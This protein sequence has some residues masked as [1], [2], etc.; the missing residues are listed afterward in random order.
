MHHDLGEFLNREHPDKTFGVEP[1]HVLVA[2]YGS[3][4]EISFYTSLANIDVCGT[5]ITKGDSLVIL[6]D[7]TNERRCLAVRSTDRV[8]SGVSGE[9]Y[10]LLDGNV[11]DGKNLEKE[12]VLADRSRLF[13][14]VLRHFPDDAVR[15]LQKEFWELED[16]GIKL[17]KDGVEEVTSIELV[18]YFG[19][20][21]RE[22]GK[23]LHAC[24]VEWFGEVYYAI[25]DVGVDSNK[26][27]KAI[28]SNSGSVTGFGSGFRCVSSDGRE[29]ASFGGVLFVSGEKW[30][31][32]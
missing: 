13:A 31:S 20:L 26:I 21:V 5:L 15:K 32:A 24:A 2:S 7:L 1:R 27:I 23:F 14:E 28:N 17:E 18:S 16:F 12:R 8:V 10:R 9:K 29:H 11:I 30:G 3:T 25:V 19:S 4:T 22:D 6:V